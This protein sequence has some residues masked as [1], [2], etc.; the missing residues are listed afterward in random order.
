[1]APFTYAVEASGDLAHWSVLGAAPVLTA[2]QSELPPLIKPV[3]LILPISGASYLRVRATWT[4]SCGHSPFADSD[5]DSE[6]A[7]FSQP[8]PIAI[9]FRLDVG[10]THHAM[11]FA[12]LNRVL[13]RWGALAVALPV[14]LVIL[15]GLLLLLKK[16]L[17]WIQPPT[18]KGSSQELSLSFD[19]ILEVAQ[20]VPEAG[21]ASWD[22]IDRLDVRPSKGMLKVRSTNRQEIQIDA[23][24]GEVL[25]V[26]FRRSDFIESLHDG[27]FFHENAKLWLFLPSALILLSLWVTGIYLFLLPYLVR[28]KRKKKAAAQ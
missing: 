9:A 28:R 21:I 26:A 22:D 7:L 2:D 16:D 14:L 24:T 1:M 13:H 5:R 17:A 6:R 15:T 12:K 11:N 4:G 19:R 10:L 27:S 3:S 8:G 25:Q 20:S 23:R 18:Q